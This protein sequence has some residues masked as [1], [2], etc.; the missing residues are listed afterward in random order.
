[1]LNA[2]SRASP[3]WLTLT[4]LYYKGILF[5]LLYFLTN[6]Y[7]YFIVFTYTLNFKI[8]TILIKIIQRILENICFFFLNIKH[9]IKFF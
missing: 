9:K 7:F 8:F 4:S 1:M 6:L 2:M 3:I 5:S